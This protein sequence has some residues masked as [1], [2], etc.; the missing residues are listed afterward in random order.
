MVEEEVD[1]SEVLFCKN[2]KKFDAE[3]RTCD[4]QK[5][6]VN[7]EGH[8]GI[9]DFDKERYDKRQKA[10]NARIPEIKLPGIGKL[11]STFA[12]EISETLKDSREIFY[13]PRENR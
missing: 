6:E 12:V 9:F 8:C 11:I 13:R 5:G 3:T 4:Y 2:C 7:P 1:I 10:L